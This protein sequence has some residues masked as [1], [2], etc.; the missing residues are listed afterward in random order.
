MFHICLNQFQSN[1]KFMYV[2]EI[3]MFVSGSC[4]IIMIF[5]KFCV[6]VS[7]YCRHTQ[8]V[9]FKFYVFFVVKI[10]NSHNFSYIDNKF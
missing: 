9:Y 6:V 2:K 3:H 5:I 1:Q 7:F 4:I 10:E 8:C